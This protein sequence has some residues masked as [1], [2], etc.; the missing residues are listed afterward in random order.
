MNSQ[1]VNDTIDNLDLPRQGIAADTEDGGYVVVSAAPYS[2]GYPRRHL[3][4]GVD[5]T[6]QEAE[7]ALR[8]FLS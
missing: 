1:Q 7:D 3:Y 2:Q 6:P 5:A 8:R 4:I